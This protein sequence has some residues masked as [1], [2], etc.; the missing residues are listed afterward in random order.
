MVARVSFCFHRAVNKEADLY[1]LRQIAASDA[2][3]MHVVIGDGAGFHHRDGASELPNNLKL[4]TLPAYSLE[5]NPVE[6]FG[7]ITKDTLC[8]IAW[9]SLEA[10]EEKITVTLKNYWENSSKVLSL[11]TNS[12]LR[13]ELNAS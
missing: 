7:D 12:Y 9:P 2:D 5:L 10:L 6:K 3:A 4:I 13:F 8:N 1:F 11:F